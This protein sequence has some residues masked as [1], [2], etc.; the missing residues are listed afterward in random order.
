MEPTSSSLAGAVRPNPVQR[1]NS[2]GFPVARI[3][4]AADFEMLSTVSKVQTGRV[5]RGSWPAR[6]DSPMR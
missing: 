3:R 1:C 6:E 4:F 5:R 2:Q